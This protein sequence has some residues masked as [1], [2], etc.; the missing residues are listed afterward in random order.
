MRKQPAVQPLDWS[1]IRLKSREQRSHKVG[2]AALAQPAAAGA[3]FAEWLAGLPAFLGVN[4]LRAIVDAVVAA[5]QAG[6][7]VVFAYGGH[8]IKTGCTPLVVD[9]IERGIV[10]AVATNGSGAIHDLELAETGATSEEVAD[11]I[12]DG[13]FG[14]VHETCERM[15]AAAERGSDGRGL[16]RALGEL[17][18]AAEAPYRQHS[19][20]VAAARAGI[21]ATVHVA[22]GTDTVHMHPAA[23][24][25][26]IGAASMADFRTLCAVVADL[27]AAES[28]A[29]GGVWLNCGSAVV[30]PEVFLKAVSVARNLG[31]P[32]DGMHTAN[33]DMLQ[34]YRP[35]QNVLKRPVAPGHGHA[36]IGQHEILLPLLRQ[37]VIE[38]LPA[39]L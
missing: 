19:I 35:V 25:A 5:R 34:H 36:I 18:D 37:A 20:M 10:T 17:L 4:E 8:V 16:G 13:S 1:R 30:M 31:H 38:R 9:L 27:G 11:T 12:R 39:A 2:T 21:P 33:L 14:M 26:A 7:P 6:R 32:L 3:T 28:G 22:V 23:D 15:N 29:A 24:G